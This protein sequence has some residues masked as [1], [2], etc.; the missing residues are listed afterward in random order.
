[1]A[2]PNSFFGR[3]YEQRERAPRAA[4]FGLVG[5]STGGNRRDGLKGLEGGRLAQVDEVKPRTSETILSLAS[6]REYHVPKA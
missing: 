3:H 4:R 6:T 2:P 5:E 1:M